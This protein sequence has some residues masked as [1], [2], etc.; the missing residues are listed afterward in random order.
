MCAIESYRKSPNPVQP[1]SF[2]LDGLLDK[3]FAGYLK[4][5]RDKSYRLG[6]EFQYFSIPDNFDDIPYVKINDI[7]DIFNYNYWFFW[8]E[9][10]VDDI[11]YSFIPVKRIE[12]THLERF[13]EELLSILP[14]DIDEIDKEEILLSTSGSVCHNPGK[15]K[16]VY[17]VKERNNTF[18]NDPLRGKRSMIFVSP[19]NTR[20]SIILPVEQSNSVKLIEMQVARICEKVTGSAYVRDDEQFKAILD[21]FYDEELFYLDRD[22]KKEGLTKPRELI[23]ATLEVL[24]YRYPGLD[25]WKYTG[26]FNGLSIIDFDGKERS[27]RRG[28]GLG[29]SNALTTLIQIVIFKLALDGLFEEFGNIALTSKCLAYNDDFTASFT[30]EYLC[31][32]YWDH[33]DFWMDALGIIRNEKKSFKGR[34]KFSFCERY[35]PEPMGRKTSYRLTEFNNAFSCPNISA[36]KMYVNNLSR[37]VHPYSFEDYIKELVSY[38]GYEF[39]YEEWKSSYLFGG[40]VTPVLNLVDLSFAVIDQEINDDMEKAF[41]ACKKK[42]F[43]FN[44]FSNDRRRYISP[45]EN[46]TN[47]DDLFI[48]EKFNLYVNYGVE[49]YKVD[50]LYLMRN[51]DDFLNK[52]FVKFCNERQN[53]FTDHKPIG[54]NRSDL[55]KIIF[56]ENPDIDFLPPISL[57]RKGEVKFFEPEDED[58]FIVPS[59]ANSI[60]SM[61]KFYNDTKISD[62]HI[63]FINSSMSGY[64]YK[65]FKLSD[66]EYL[67]NRLFQDTAHGMI[68]SCT[69][70]EY[71][72]SVNGNTSGYIN[73]NNVINACFFIYKILCYPEIRFLEKPIERFIKHPKLEFILSSRWRKKIFTFL[74]KRL[75]FKK[76]YKDYCLYGDE[77]FKELCSSLTPKKEDKDEQ[78]LPGEDV[79][80]KG[81]RF[82]EYVEWCKD[83]HPNFMP[84]DK[85][86]LLFFSFIR[87]IREQMMAAQDQF[88]EDGIESAEW[89]I[90]FI[91]NEANQI[92]V[93]LSGGVISRPRPNYVFIS[94]SELDSY[95]DDEDSEGSFDLFE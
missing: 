50:S 75:G 13:K 47:R 25:A 21:S 19:D 93:Q 94:Y 64:M 57:I 32:S 42:F 48:P 79:P 18:S 8:K 38:W 33:E 72:Y 76:V 77:F 83:G 5:I 95:E 41:F 87:E 22:I 16:M 80:R 66:Q 26:I 85:E 82:W 20:D 10:P 78:D 35:Y 67:S 92:K 54:L 3:Q 71:I 15:G 81:Y 61:V 30:E 6:E 34:G 40:W 88:Y 58:D 2:L 59:T 74:V 65:Q 89:L 28:T 24:E 91:D 43:Q 36:A 7:G 55:F 49:K 51:N 17:Q 90:D 12:P 1:I 84:Y 31:D 62:K 46:I 53:R 56:K 44:K 4:D 14:D 27:T 69:R 23:K 60:L 70:Y 39:Y 11:E 9:D 86:P 73:P 29:M 63:P 52:M 68:E 45:L 37:N